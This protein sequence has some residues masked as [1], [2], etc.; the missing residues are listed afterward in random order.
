MITAGLIILAV[1]AANAAVGLRPGARLW[2]DDCLQALS[3]VAAGAVPDPKD[4]RPAA[5]L[6]KGVVPLRYDVAARVA[7]A[8]RRLEIGDIVHRWPESQ[9]DAVRPGDVLTAS[10][11]EGGV[12][13]YRRVTALQPALPGQG[14]FVTDGDGHVLT[15]HYERR[16]Q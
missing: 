3:P 10:V 9:S 14:L 8:G 5:C 1:T 12:R 16:P 11:A 4:F 13:I 2:Q 7:R 6:V 15:A